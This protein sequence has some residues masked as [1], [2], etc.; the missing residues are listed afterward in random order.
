[1]SEQRDTRTGD[2]QPL[3]EQVRRK[4]EAAAARH[5]DAYWA[6]LRDRFGVTA[7]PE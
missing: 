4:L 2:P 6:A 3:R 1:M 7:E 5:D